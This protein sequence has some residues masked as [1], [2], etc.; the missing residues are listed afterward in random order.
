MEKTFRLP[1]HIGIIMDGNGRWA[2]MRGKKRTA[3]HKAGTENVDKIASH[4]FE[5]GVKVLS[6]FA[7]SSENFARPEEEVSALMD[8]IDKYLGRFLKKAT[9]EKVGLRIIGDITPLSQKL[10]DRIKLITEKTGKF[11][12]KI[13]NIGLNYGGRADIVHAVTDIVK[14]GKQI[15]EEEIDNH[16]YTADLPK[17]DLI[18]RT[19]GEKRLSNFMLFQAAYSELYFTDVLWPDFGA[20]ELDEAIEDYLKRDR[21]YGKIERK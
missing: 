19:G 7:F 20:K 17:P 21:R 18:I 9:K 2:E 1:E 16:L 5:R 11:K 4:A 14:E 6:L 10:K 8:L 12:D 13:L 15:T 3:G